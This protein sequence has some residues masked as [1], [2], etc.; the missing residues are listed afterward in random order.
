MVN[1]IPVASGYQ[2]PG[3]PPITDRYKRTIM[4]RSIGRMALTLVLLCGGTALASD[5]E[6]ADREA[7]RE[8]IRSLDMDLSVQGIEPTPV[9]NLYAV[10]L[11]RRTVY[12][13]ADGRYLLRGDLLDLAERRNLTRERE[14]Q[15]GA[16][17]LRELPEDE[18]IVYEPDGEARYEVTVF[19]DISC[20][21]C[22]RFHRQLDAYLERGI[23]IRYA[24]MPRAGPGSSAYD[25]AVAVWCADNS[26]R[27]MT[28]A[29][30][31]E[32]VPTASCDNPI[33]EHT[34]L[35]R[36]LGVR[37]T[38]GILTSDGR[39]VGGYLP[40]EKLAQALASDSD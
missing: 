26:H 33:K 30:Q 8:R 13:T 25:K 2:E 18:L 34:R 9:A 11:G 6:K 1:I 27:A 12:V 23:R 22:R 29:K 14:R 7:I 5:D 32:S 36:R 3:M 10:D 37:G 17:A 35:A 38:P 20:P 21:Y 39:Q 16:S 31:G 19:T 15:G 4:M 40:P 28:R 24:F